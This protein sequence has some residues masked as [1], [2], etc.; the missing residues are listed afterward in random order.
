ME[1]I[2]RLYLYYGISKPREIVNR[3]DKYRKIY[4]LYCLFESSDMIRNKYLVDEN[5]TA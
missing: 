4:G 3:I 1:E 2:R 5:L